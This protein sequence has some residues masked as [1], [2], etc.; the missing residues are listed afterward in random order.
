MNRLSALAFAVF[1]L[2]LPAVAPAQNA[3]PQAAAAAPSMQYNDPAMSFTAPEG[4]KPLPVPSHDP[5]VFEDPA[6]MAAYVKDAGSRN[7]MS[8]VLRMQNYDGSPDGWA[9]TSDNDLRT[10]SN[11]AFISRTATKLAN[12]MPVFWE[13]VTVGSGFDQ[14]KTYQYIWADGVRGVTLSLICRDGVITDEQA[15]QMLSNLSAVAYP[16]YRY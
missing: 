5:A 12:G 6:V 4:F 14:I 15:K 13:D 9:T 3:A 2:L 7:A 16:K 11:G 8:I 1:A 10:N